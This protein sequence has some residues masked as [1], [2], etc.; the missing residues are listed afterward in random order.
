[1]E[2]RHALAA[3]IFFSVALVHAA[4]IALPPAGKL[5]HGFYFGG[6]GTDSHDPTEHDHENYPHQN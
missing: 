3:L 4:P 6:V 2:R 1:M 5:Y